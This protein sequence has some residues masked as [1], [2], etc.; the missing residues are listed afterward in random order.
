[1][2]ILLRL[3]KKGVYVKKKSTPINSSADYLTDINL[4]QSAWIIVYFNLMI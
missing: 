2:N 1:M 3:L 4:Y